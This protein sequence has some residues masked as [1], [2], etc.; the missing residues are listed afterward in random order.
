MKFEHMV[1]RNRGQKSFKMDTSRDYHHKYFFDVNLISFKNIKFSGKLFTNNKYK[2]LLKTEIRTKNRNFSQKIEIFAKH[3]F[4]FPKS[5]FCLK[6][7]CC[8]ISL[9]NF[10]TFP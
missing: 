9:S 6:S 1:C 8:R 4:F 10:Q 5:K 3:Q 2:N 7:K